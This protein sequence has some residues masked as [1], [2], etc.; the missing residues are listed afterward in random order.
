MGKRRT[1]KRRLSKNRRHSTT[2]R[3]SFLHPPERERERKR[4][5]GKN[6]YRKEEQEGDD[7][8]GVDRR[9]IN[10]LYLGTFFNLLY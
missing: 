2:F 6:G 9:S 10:S 1:K 3:D 8:A 5:W 7:P 4:R